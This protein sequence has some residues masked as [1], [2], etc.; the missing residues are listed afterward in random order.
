MKEID[1]DHVLHGKAVID[2]DTFDY[3]AKHVIVYKDGTLSY[4]GRATATGKTGVFHAEVEDL[5]DKLEE[6]EWNAIEIEDN[7]ED[8]K[9]LKE[10]V[11]KGKFRI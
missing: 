3:V 10:G 7:I 11:E 4:V 9:K 2:P 6:E 1:D 5:T 8:V